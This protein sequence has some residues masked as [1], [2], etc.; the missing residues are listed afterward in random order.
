MLPIGYSVALYGTQTLQFLISN[1]LS[2][3]DFRLMLSKWLCFYP[4]FRDSFSRDL[5]RRAL[6]L[7]LE[8]SSRDLDFAGLKLVPGTY[9]KEEVL[10]QVAVLSMLASDLVYE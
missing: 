2:P 4:N 8:I 10:L 9:S 7:V 1:Q 5:T 6:A 3:D